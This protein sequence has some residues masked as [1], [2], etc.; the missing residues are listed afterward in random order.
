MTLLEKMRYQKVYHEQ[1]LEM[2][3]GKVG[4][5]SCAPTCCHEK[6][7]PP[8]QGHKKKRESKSNIENEEEFLQTQNMVND[9]RD[10]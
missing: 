5:P 7:T 1:R 2:C 9:H 8:V 3:S 6:D 10:L 4:S